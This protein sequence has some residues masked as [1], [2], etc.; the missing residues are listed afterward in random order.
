MSKKVRPICLPY[1]CYEEPGAST[2]RAAGWGETMSKNSD[3]KILKEIDLDV[4]HDKECEKVNPFPSSPIFKSQICTWSNKKDTCV[5]DDG[6]PLI[7]S[8]KF[9]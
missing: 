7:D 5:G 3:T 2:L 6:G 8:S 4:I 9:Y 1:Y